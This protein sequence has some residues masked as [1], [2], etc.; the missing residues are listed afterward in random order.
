MRGGNTAFAAIIA[1]VLGAGL[2]L[3]LNGGAPPAQAATN[4]YFTQI[5]AG[6][7]DTCGILNDGRIVCWGQNSTGSTQPPAG[8]F[9]QISLYSVHG[10]AIRPDQTATCWGGGAYGQTTLPMPSPTDHFL[11]VSS[12]YSHSCGVR[13]D[14][15]VV[16]WGAN[17]S[18]ESTPPSG[19]HFSQVS[20]GTFFTCGVTT[21]GD[22]RCWGAGDASGNLNPPGG[23]FKAVS[24]GVY[25]ACG[26]KSDG[27]LACWGQD[28]DGEGTPP[29]GTFS[30]VS[31]GAT[32]AC[33]LRTDS[34]IAC[35]G[36]NPFDVFAAPQSPPSGTGFTQV[37]IDDTHA[38]A[39]KSD[40]SVVCWG[41]TGV[42]ESTP[43]TAPVITQQ[44]QGLT[45][46]AGQPFT[47]SVDVD[48]TPTPTYQW[49]HDGNPIPGANGSSYSVPA[50]SV[51]DSGSYD[52]LISNEMGSLTSQAVRVAVLSW[53]IPAPISYGTPLG[54]QQLN[55]TVMDGSTSVAGTLTYEPAAGTV[56]SPGAQTLK[57]SFVPNDTTTYV[58]ATATVQLTVNQATP[59]IT[60]PTPA[61]MT[62]G[63]PLSDA[64]LNATASVPG[65]FSYTPAAGM[66]LNAGTQP[67]SVRFTPADQVDYTSPSASVLLTVQQA[68]PTIT[69]SP[70][71]SIGYGSDLSSVL[72]GGASVPGSISYTLANGTPLT[73]DR[74]LDAGSYTLRASFTPSD[75]RDY[76]SV[77]TSAALSVTPAPLIVTADDQTKLVG[78]PNPSLTGTIVGVR[79]S[80][81]I[82]ATY[83]TPATVDS[84]AGS[85]PIVPALVDPDGRLGN[86]VVTVVNGT[87]TVKENLV[88]LF[89]QSKPI[90]AGSTA[91]IKIQLIDASGNNIS[92]PDVTL[93]AV[94]L[95]SADGTLYPVKS[96][97]NSQPGNNFR[98]DP[99]L[100]GSG[101][102][103]F[104]L[105][106]TG[107]SSG[108]YTLHFTVGDSPTLHEVQLT[109]G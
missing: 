30:Q 70:P 44:P 109:I 67:L 17:D 54:L 22:V 87:L 102:Y 15:T 60:W 35:W 26:I 66:V 37:S 28:H 92:S 4:S 50:A 84:P 2:A 39:L 107:L 31:V 88:A 25:L 72:N 33:G 7:A 86:Y 77:S 3:G 85:Y 82:S 93:H 9:T 90:Q 42:G 106:T 71:A 8:S 24:A 40:G 13:T 89:D 51:A 78:D 91:V 46:I 18:G 96:P 62:Y 29:A 57:V 104:N 55:A 73:A 101:G 108:V 79:N 80:D 16:C 100:G 69:W 81:A 103:S 11:Q 43:P 94:D 34:T 65:T 6:F 20:A 52:V 64:Q 23:S 41:D 19:T 97:G 1:L 99:T 75:A 21:G 83:S 58:P 63:A 59:T 47:L 56:L 14:N 5:S 32:G 105:K 36:N 74:V 98:Y 95:E 38:C 49:R 27:T 68:T 76:A 12:G 10:C 53:P 48:G 45:A 61:P